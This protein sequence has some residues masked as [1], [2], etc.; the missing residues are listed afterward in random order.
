MKHLAKISL[1]AFAAIAFA[2][3]SPTLDPTVFLN[4]L[5]VDIDDLKSRSGDFEQVKRLLGE[6]RQIDTGDAA[7]YEGRVQYIL[8]DGSQSIVFK[9]GE[10]TQGYAVEHA[11]ARDRLTISVLDPSIKSI[12]VGGLRLGMNKREADKVFSG[13]PS[14]G[15]K[16]EDYRNPSNRLRWTPP[17]KHEP[18]GSRFTYQKTVSRGG[19]EFCDRIWIGLRFDSHSKLDFFEVTFGGCDDMPCEDR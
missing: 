5:G 18:N 10:C 15:W 14:D 9:I 4:V 8:N 16:V 1:F 2:T 17:E 7:E 19:G 3:S 11:N 12:S 6:A 13:V